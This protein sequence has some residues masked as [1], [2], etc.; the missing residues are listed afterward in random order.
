[1]PDKKGSGAG[2]GSVI[3]PCYRMY[4]IYSVN[5]EYLKPNNIFCKVY[6]LLKT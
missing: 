2:C 4:N 3:H 1:M 6:D 5:D